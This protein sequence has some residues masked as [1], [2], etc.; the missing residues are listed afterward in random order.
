MRRSAPISVALALMTM[1]GMTSAC[2]DMGKE[3]STLVAPQVLGARATP[4]TVT[5]G[6]TVTL[7]AVTYG[8]DTLEWYVCFAPYIPDGDP[9]CA[10]APEADEL[11]LGSGDTVE[12]TIP[13]EATFAAFGVDVPGVYVRMVATTDD[14]HQISVATN[15]VGQSGQHPS[16]TGFTNADDEQPQLDVQTEDEFVLK[17]RLELPS[18]DDD[19]LVTWFV[20]GGE[21]DPFRTRNDA[22]VTIRTS[23]DSGP[24]RV[25]RS[26][27][28]VILASAGMTSNSR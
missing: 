3:P 12:L 17:P 11:P 7:E 15:P 26:S 24:M 18:S 23:S 8:V 25:S 22:E 19:V 20:E 13:D 6:T 21:A 16:I 1:A 28:T 9:R 5:Y 2:N 27:E 4:R 14:G 10:T